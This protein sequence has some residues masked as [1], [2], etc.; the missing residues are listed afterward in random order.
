M[1]T[2]EERKKNTEK[3]IEEIGRKNRLELR[4]TREDERRMNQHRNFIIGDLVAKHFP[5]V[6]SIE[7]GTQTENADRFRK[8][9]AFLAELAE[10][11]TLVSQIKKRAENRIL[12]GV[13]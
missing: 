6:M 9:D 1:L 3:R 10:D 12:K 13:T 7:P 5:E 2:I 11:Q 8:V 4:R